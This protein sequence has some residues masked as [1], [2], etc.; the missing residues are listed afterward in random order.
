MH[1]KYSYLLTRVLTRCLNPLY[2]TLAIG[3][4]ISAMVAII[5]LHIFESFAYCMIFVKACVSYSCFVEYSDMTWPLI[6]THLSRWNI[7][8]YCT[9]SFCNPGLDKDFNGQSFLRRSAPKGTSGDCGWVG[10]GGVGTGWGKDKRVRDFKYLQV[11]EC[12][13]YILLLYSTTNI[14]CKQMYTI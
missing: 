13:S 1:I 6:F 12:Y 5:S 14:S 7:L 2:S 8:L 11:F 4:I 3:A 9:C 10:W